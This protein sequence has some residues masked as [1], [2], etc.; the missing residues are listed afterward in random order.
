MRFSTVLRGNARRLSLI[1]VAAVL[2]LGLAACSSDDEDVAGT[3][4]TQALNK[5]YA[6]LAGQASS[7]AGEKADESFWDS[8]NPFSG[9]DSPGEQLSARLLTTRRNPRPAEPNPKPRR[10]SAPSRPPRAPA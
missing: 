1:A 2:M 4:F 3:P 6:D 8:L 5:D 7:L 10:R 9:G